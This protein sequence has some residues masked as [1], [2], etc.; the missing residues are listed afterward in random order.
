ML[1]PAVYVLV[2]VQSSSEVPEGLMNNPVY[3]CIWRTGRTTPHI[4]MLSNR[5]EISLNL[6]LRF[7]Q[8]PPVANESVAD[9]IH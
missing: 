3:K 5:S 1:L 4:L 2:V 7:Q 9:L 8:I 6:L